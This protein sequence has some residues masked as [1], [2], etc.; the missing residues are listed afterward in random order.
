MPKLTINGIEIEV[1]KGT[2]I[3]QAAEQLGVE[4]PRFC[5]HDKLSVPANCRMCLVQV[6]G[7]PP[8]PVASCAM[9]CGDGMIVHTESDMVKKARKGVMEMLLINHPLDCPICDQGG[10][11]DLQD[12]AM[13]YGFDRS[14]FY[15]NKRAVPD[16][17]LGPLIKTSMNRCINCT[18]CVRFAEEV[19]GTPVLG[20]FHRGEEA[21]IG[22]FIDQLV[23]TELSGNLIDVCPVGALTSKPYAFKARA[24]ELRKT[25]TIDVHD[26]LGSNIRVD[27]RGREVM[28]VLP[29]LHEDINEEWIDDR[30]RFAYDG[31]QRGRIDRPYIRDEK[32]GKLIEATWDEA[33]ATIAARM[34]GVRGVESAGLV[35]DMADLE[36]IVALKDFLTYLGSPNMDCRT[37]GSSFDV[38]ERSGYLFNS[39]IAGIEQADAILLVGTNPRWEATLV[40][41]RIRKMYLEKRIKVAVVGEAADLTYPYEH[42]GNG[43]DAVEKSRMFF[44]KAEKPMMIVGSGAFMREDG[45]AVHHAL[46]EIA[47]KS[48]V[49][50]DGWN[51][52]NILHRAASRVGA[53]EAGFVPQ[54]KGK[55]F[56]E[57]LEGTKNGTIKMLY[58]LGADEFDARSQIGW[59]TFVIYQGHHGDHGA[60]RAD[61]VLPGAAYTE[62][63]AIYV[64]TEG[65]PQLAKRAASTP[66]EAREDWKIIRALSAHLGVKL[67]Y[68]TSVQLRQRIAHEWPHLVDINV[69][70]PAKWA[71]FGEKGKHQKESFRS[72][73]RNFYLTNAICR[74]S[75]TMRK[76]S[77]SFLEKEQFA[78]AAE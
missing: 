17:E 31:L 30:T 53:L 63:D 71:E 56:H 4:I 66:G 52:F 76:C 9:A 69:I 58:L 50:K 35:G 25:E 39:T 27:V 75:E 67:A 38:N 32:S 13:A 49:V 45:V 73:V 42:L 70:K 20:Q 59:Q 1:E 51:G 24:W 5:Y 11:C 37:D 48:G 12:Q 14:R 64:N 21:E 40:N 16:K 22:T 26:A 3:L 44:G 18:R 77:A 78:E 61:I 10:E 41:A 72:P 33:F 15:E 54:K 46:R 19:A 23:K 62:K 34:K 29:R 6:E 2:S 7:G 43:P 74:A 8:K 28:R 47:V 65:R 68:D 57:I 55:N 60:A 36:S